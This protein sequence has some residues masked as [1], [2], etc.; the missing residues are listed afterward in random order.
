MRRQFTHALAAAVATGGAILLTAGLAM[1]AAASSRAVAAR[2]ATVSTSHT[3]GYVTGGGRHFRYVESTV[4]V[5]VARTAA[6]HAEVTLGGAGATP[7]FLGV[8]AGGGANSVGWAIGVQPFGTGGGALAKLAPDPGDLMRLSI[9]YDQQG[10]IFFTAVDATKGV[11]QTAQ[12]TVGSSTLF[13]AAEAAVYET[14][15]TATVTSDFKLWAFTG[16]K[17]TT[18][19]GVKGTLLG[20]WTTS[21]V[22]AV[23]GGSVVM[24]PSVLFS[25]GADFNIWRR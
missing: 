10:H 6:Q 16:T 14:G 13:T 20:P 7:V 15:Y 22:V 11:T 24:S 19:T 4:K 25:S 17:V 21:Q 3:A 9:Y 5:S 12:A 2:A 1:P 18:Y 23:A 8:K